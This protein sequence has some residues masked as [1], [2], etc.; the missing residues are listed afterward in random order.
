MGKAPESWHLVTHRWHGVTQKNKVINDI[1]VSLK[2]GCG[3]HLPKPFILMGHTEDAAI[4]A[5]GILLHLE[6]DVGT[7]TSGE[8]QVL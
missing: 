3:A 5:A 7:P 2:A 6:L 1:Q 4:S 8:Q